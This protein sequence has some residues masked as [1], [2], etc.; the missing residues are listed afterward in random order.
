VAGEWLRIWRRESGD[1]LA[2]DGA[3]LSRAGLDRRAH[4]DEPRLRLE[5]REDP[6]CARGLP[7]LGSGVRRYLHH[8]VER[9]I[10]PGAQLASLVRE[11]RERIRP[12][13]VDRKEAIPA[14]R[15]AHRPA[16]R[17]ARRHP[18]RDARLLYLLQG[19]GHPS[20][21]SPGTIRARLAAVSRAAGAR[22]A[23]GSPLVVKPHDCRRIFASEHLNNNTPVHVIQALLGHATLDTVMVYAKLLAAGR[24]PAGPGRSVRAVRRTGRRGGG[25]L[26]LG[27]RGG[28]RR[29]PRVGHRSPAAGGDGPF[30]LEER[31]SF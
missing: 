23:N 2:P 12:R 17:P 24:V 29:L 10:G 26:D 13:K 22:K 4:I 18:H 30:V 25:H 11:L 15:A 21:I 20:A 19:L 6:A 16:M 9:I 28:V 8:E 31:S 14:G 1:P 27:F 3:L 5:A 7:G